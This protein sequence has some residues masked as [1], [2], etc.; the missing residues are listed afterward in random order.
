[1]SSNPTTNME[2]EARAALRRDLELIFEEGWVYSR[3]GA[4]VYE[5]II[6]RRC[7][8]IDALALCDIYGDCLGDGPTA[9]EQYLDRFAPQQPG[10]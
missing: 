7:P 5:S 6:A 9:T 4:V 3:G 2:S 10:A 8:D 1:M